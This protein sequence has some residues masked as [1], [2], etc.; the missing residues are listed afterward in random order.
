ML[1]ASARCP[2]DNEIVAFT[3][4]LVRGAGAAAIEV[5]MDMCPDC[6]IILTELAQS[7]SIERT[8]SDAMC[9]VEAQA[10][11][12]T[13][14]TLPGEQ[15][16]P[17]QMLG[18]RF[19]LLHRLGTGGMGQVYE[20]EDTVLGVPV[21][22]KLLPPVGTSPQLVS[23]LHQEILLGRR[24]SHPNVCRIYD[25]GTSGDLHFLTMELLD[26]DTLAERLARGPIAYPK[27]CR[28]I[29][30]MVAALAAAH[31]E[32]VVHR[33]LKPSTIMVGK[34]GQVKVMDFGLARDYR[35]QPVGRTRPVGTPAYWAPEQ[36]RG[37]VATEA[38]DVYALG[39]V[40][41]EILSGQRRKSGL[42]T[43][44]RPL[45]Q[46]VARCLA[47]SPASR[48]ASAVELEARLGQLSRARRRRRAH[49]MTMLPAGAAIVAAVL[50]LAT[51]TWR[52]H[53]ETPEPD[54]R[55]AATARGAP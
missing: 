17:G 30:Q 41:L 53:A 48:F 34:N 4:G 54:A 25:L 42:A 27:A 1:N 24:V 45:R 44:P 21:A 15:Y 29:E 10:E 37:E 2:D 47:D 9:D 8:W 51:M 13:A 22:V 5:H 23:Q 40:M 49:L 50:V 26:G 7:S 55:A 38:S 32:G 36:A 6:R 12:G 3:A 11:L 28:I 46:V 31:R 19:C 43:I 18:D 35:L 39:L 33:D 14:V 16:V 20:A 52:S